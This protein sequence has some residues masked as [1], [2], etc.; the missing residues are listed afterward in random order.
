MYKATARGYYTDMIDIIQGILSAA[1]KDSSDIFKGFITGI[2]HI[3]YQS[4]YSGF[5]N[6]DLC[7]I[8][9]PFC[10]DFIGFTK[11]ETADL[12]KCFSMENRIP[13]VI[14]RY[15]GYSFAGADLVCPEGVIRFLAQAFRPGN[16]PAAFPLE[17]SR[18]NFSENDIIGIFMKHA[19]VRDSERIQQ[20]LEGKTEKLSSGNSPPIR[21]VPQTLILL[22][23]P[24]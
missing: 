6:Y 9:D 24:P 11:T 4:I 3:S 10:C 14:E 8:N 1:L 19:R 17:N 12:L 13:D 15:G 5:N 23:S 21:P 7:S 22:P 2:H 18:L 20:L 16:N